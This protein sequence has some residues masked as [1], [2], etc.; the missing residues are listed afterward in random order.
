MKMELDYSFQEDHGEGETMIGDEIRSKVMKVAENFEART[1]QKP[2]FL[3][4]GAEELLLL[5]YAYKRPQLEEIFAGMK[6]IEVCKDHHMDV[7]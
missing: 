7:S 2:Q 3:Y 6:I 1:G 4:L 5:L